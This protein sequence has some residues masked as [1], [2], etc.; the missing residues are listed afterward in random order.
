MDMEKVLNLVPL[1]AYYPRWAQV[2][3]FAAFGSL[4]ASLF[5]FLLLYGHAV[6]LK[7]AAEAAKPKKEIPAHIQQSMNEDLRV[8]SAL[9]SDLG[10]ALTDYYSTAV[11]LRLHMLDY[12]SRRPNVNDY[13]AEELPPALRQDVVVVAK[14]LEAIRNALLAINRNSFARKCW[15]QSSR[16][17]RDSYL[18]R[19]QQK[20][21]DVGY[22]EREA[23]VPI[24]DLPQISQFFALASNRLGNPDFTTILSP[25]LATNSADI[26]GVSMRYDS[27][28][29]RSLIFS[30]NILFSFMG[31]SKTQ[32]PRKF[33][34][35]WGTA[36]LHDTCE[37]LPD[38][39][40]FRAAL[41]ETYP[42]FSAIISEMSDINADSKNSVSTDLKSAIATLEQKSGLIFLLLPSDKVVHPQR[43]PGAPRP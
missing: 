33:V 6:Q 12:T 23:A 19:L 1:I 9:F 11:A 20:L 3:F 27:A 43:A 22:S 40:S 24:D 10:L 31:D 35:S 13:L 37:S 8:S 14:G 29:L 28:E 7:E 25:V 5:V 42:S 34:A 30:G 18:R 2:L 21:Q 16:A 26:D 36:I 17:L 41:S 15:Q 4:T 39:A 38:A 32:E